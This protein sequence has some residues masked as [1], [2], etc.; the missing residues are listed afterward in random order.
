MSFRSIVVSLIATSAIA[1]APRSESVRADDV[2]YFEKDGVTYRE[3]RQ[4]IQRPVTELR[5]AQLPQTTYRP[6]VANGTQSVT[7]SYMAPVT[8]YKSH[9]RLVGRWNPFVRQPYWEQRQVPITRWELKT[10]TVQVPANA[11]TLVPQTTAVPAPVASTRMVE[12]EIISRVAV[13][14]RA[15]GSPTP[16]PVATAQVAAAPIRSA[17]AQ[18]APLGIVPNRSPV[19]PAAV[20]SRPTP[21][22]GISKL[23]QDPP[24]VGN[25]VQW[26]PADV[27][28]R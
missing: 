4:K 26:R 13:A 7:R 23:D 28:R 24:R 1:A 15:P 20:G 2:T 25:N 9:W 22:G 21:F 27:T 18:A 5:Y 8:E 19:S 3:T 17:P 14:T 6:T 10:D 12:D 11:P 16:T